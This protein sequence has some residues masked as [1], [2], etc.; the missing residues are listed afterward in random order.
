MGFSFGRVVEKTEL[1]PRLI[2]II[3]AIDDL[4]QL[5]VPDVA[6]AAVGI[7][8]PEPG[9]RKAPAMENRDGVWS[10]YDINPMPEGR[11]YSVRHLDRRT[12]TMTIDFVVH[13]HGTA[14]LWAQRTGI[15]EEV[16]MSHARSWY[17]PE[18]TTEWQLLV[19]DLAGLPALARILEEL[20]AN[21]RVTAIVEVCDDE[22][23]AYLPKRADVEVI[24]KVGSGNGFGE[25]KL[26]DAVEEFVHTDGRGYCWFAAE[27][28]ASR[29]AR[30][31]LR[32]QYGWKADQCDIIGYWRF[33]GEAWARKF[34]EV[35]AE[36]F[37]VYST[38]IAEGKSE[39]IASEEFDD[40]LERAGL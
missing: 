27:A 38:A 9:E 18:P 10:Y 4:D 8:F 23:L 17:R 1:N 5:Q 21:P 13:D 36:L 2:R 12:A 32:K 29:T 11:N 15:G 7:Y 40:A 22:D 39:K 24:A 25:S 20:P 30:K 31:H 26:G 33:D 19:A 6:D 28:K 14:T 16:A 3:F 37:S 35:G 34:E